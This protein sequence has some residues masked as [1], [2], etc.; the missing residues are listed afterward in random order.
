VAH[1]FNALAR[2][3]NRLRITNVAFVVLELSFDVAEPGN[4]AARVV[5]EDTDARARRHQP[6]GQ[7]A[8]QKSRAAGYQIRSTD[9]ILT[10]PPIA[11]AEGIRTITG[12]SAARERND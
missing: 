6:P 12:C 11:V 7:R 5:V 9:H 1:H 10:F 8:A 2:P 4:T 3:L